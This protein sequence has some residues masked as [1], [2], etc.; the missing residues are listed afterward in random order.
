MSSSTSATTPP[1]LMHG[2][3]Q[4]GGGPAG[5][6][7]GLADGLFD[8]LGVVGRAAEED[9]LAAEVHG[10]QLDVRLEVEAVAG[11]RHLEQ[12]AELAAALGRY[13]GGGQHQQVERQ[14]DVAP[15]VR[16]AVGDRHGAVGAHLRQAVVVVAR[17]DDAE[18]ARLGVVLLE[19]AEGADLL[20]PDVDRPARILFLEPD[21]VLDALLAA[22]ARAVGV[23]LVER[24]GAEH[25]AD[26]LDVLEGRV[27]VLE[28]ALQVEAGDDLRALAQ[29]VELGAVLLRAGGH[30]DDAVVDRRALAVLLLDDAGEVADEAVEVGRAR[31]RGGS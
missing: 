13:G 14:L 20:E 15:Q 28:H 1:A 31:P 3:G 30:D 7:V 25:E 5:G 27:V 23:G 22:G 6:G 19:E 21:G 24:A 29:A 26:R 8:A 2:L 18:L 12:L 16:V 9:A 4:D 11:E 10:A 17:E